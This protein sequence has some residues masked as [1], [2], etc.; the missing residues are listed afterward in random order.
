M[1]NQSIGISEISYYLG[2]SVVT[3]ED[4]ASLNP[5]WDMDK[6]TERSGVKSRPIAPPGVTA[7]DLAYEAV[8][9][10]IDAKP[11][12]LSGVDGLIFCTQTPD[13]LLPSNSNLLHGLLNL[14]LNIMAF[15][16]NHAC[17]GYPYAIGI[18]KSL[19]LSQMASKVLV[20]TADTYSRLIHPLD[21][22]V[23][24][25]FGDAA[26]ASVVSE[27]NQFHIID[28]SF[29]TAGKLASR[30][31]VERGGMRHPQKCGDDINL[32]AAQRIRSSDHIQMD[33]M[34]V[35][36]FFNKTVPDSIRE[37]LKHNNL[38]VDDISYFVLHQASQL[39]LDVLRKSLGV[40]V[41]KVIIDMSDTG[42][43]VSSSIPVVLRRSIDKALFKN[44]DKIILAGFGVGL[45][46]G[47]VLITV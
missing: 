32:D 39:A 44:G 3:N 18:A 25:L 38:S 4:L 12:I 9:K 36:S 16:I 1:H 27:C 14:P 11:N 26:S 10:I 34:G 42:N 8:K 41:E 37:I 33:G 20:V 31:I 13:Y 22:S 5:A 40:P 17:S 23:K 30:F 21:R 47:S 46:W 6:A 28:Q 2:P 19:I 29:G 45:S 35:L 15:D 7:L 24:P 43:L